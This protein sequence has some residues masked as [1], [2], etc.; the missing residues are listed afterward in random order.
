MSTKSTLPI[1]D[2]LVLAVVIIAIAGMAFG[3][4]YVTGKNHEGQ[5]AVDNGAAQYVTD[6]KTG[7]PM[8]KY[9]TQPERN[10]P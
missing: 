5:R 10:E 6:P 9:T 7:H 8:V 4:G 2:Q 3:W 1:A